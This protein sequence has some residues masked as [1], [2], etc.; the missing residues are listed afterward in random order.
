[1]SD[2]YIVH[3]ETSTKTCS[4]ALSK[5]GIVAGVKESTDDNFK[6]GEVLTLYIDSLMNEYNLSFDQLQAISVASG[7]GSYTGLRIGASTAKGLCYALGIPLIAIDSLRSLFEIKSEQAQKSNVC[8][9]IDARRMEVFSA[10]YSPDG[11]VLKDISADILEEDT[12]KEFEPLECIG[13]A[14]IKAIELWS[15]RAISFDHEL[16]A[17]ATGQAKIAYQKF[18]DS[19]FEDMAYFE[20]FYLKD[21]MAIKP[22]SQRIS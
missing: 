8:A 9:M 3:I 11:K 13:D 18:I 17:S 16:L 5:N 15:N 10:I 20:P 7:P 21:F 6:H 12:Y 22:K 14:T 4:V 2:T 1:M 19:D